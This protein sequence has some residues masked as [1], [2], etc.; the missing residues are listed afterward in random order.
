MGLERSAS[1]VLPEALFRDLARLRKEMNS[2]SPTKKRQ[3]E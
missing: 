3:R 1:F 2:K